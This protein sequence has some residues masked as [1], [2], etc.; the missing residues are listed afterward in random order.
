MFIHLM[1]DGSYFMWK[2]F[3]CLV[4]IH[5]ME[6]TSYFMWR[7]CKCFYSF[8]LRAH[9]HIYFMECALSQNVLLTLLVVHF[10]TRMYYY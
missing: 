9:E 8:F 1:E 6:D 5:L 3:K 2:E 4:F 10:V 7:E